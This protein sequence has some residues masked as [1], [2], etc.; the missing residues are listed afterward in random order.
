MK[1]AYLI[2]AHN[3][4]EILQKLIT[5]IDDKRN[6][7]FIHFDAKVKDLPKIEISFSNLYVLSNRINVCW[8]DVTVVEAELEL[9]KMAMQVGDYEYFH[10]LSGVDMPLKSQDY[11][12]NF[13]EKNKE[14]IYWVFYL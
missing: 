7:I 10:L 1:H 13:F 11:I 6:D 5:A 2:L 14:R 3:E 9:F 4:F 12:H 8:G